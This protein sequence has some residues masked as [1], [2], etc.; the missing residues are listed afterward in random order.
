MFIKTG[1]VENFVKKSVEKIQEEK[2]ETA[3]TEERV[4]IKEMTVVSTT[5][6]TGQSEDDTD[7]FPDSTPR[8]SRLALLASKSQ[9]ALTKGLNVDIL[10]DMGQLE[11]DIHENSEKFD[12]RTEKSFAWLQGINMF[13]DSTSNENFQSFLSAR[14]RFDTK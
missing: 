13:Y 12:I 1:K 5:S 6:P 9:Q 14:M 3:E 7:R 11:K 10:D 8:Q 2:D 4:S